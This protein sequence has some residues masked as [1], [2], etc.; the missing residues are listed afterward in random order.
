MPPPCRYHEAGE[1]CPHG[2]HCKY[3]HNPRRGA[4]LVRCQF[5]DHG[6][7]RFGYAC[8]FLHSDK[9]PVCHFFAR[10]QC[11]NGAACLFSHDC[12]S[13]AEE[14]VCHFFLKG[15]CKNGETCR[16]LHQQSDDQQPARSRYEETIVSPKRA[17]V[18]LER[19]SRH[20]G[21]KFCLDALLE[22]KGPLRNFIRDLGVCELANLFALLG[23]CGEV[24]EKQKYEELIGA[25]ST[26]LIIG[27]PRYIESISGEAQLL[28]C[29]KVLVDA[30]RLN[31]IFARQVPVIRLVKKSRDLEVKNE[32]LEGLLMRLKVHKNNG[33]LS[34]RSLGT[35]QKGG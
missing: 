35:P 22:Q 34:G 10:G 26:S 12:P 30:A 1:R 29:T 6:H 24:E 31:R 14:S 33:R 23:R 21:D 13:N 15:E 11:R 20:K 27:A 16:F 5:Y 19:V 17:A 25:L 18:F 2:L 32:T 28:A 8:Q 7:C 9:K 3:Y 4:A